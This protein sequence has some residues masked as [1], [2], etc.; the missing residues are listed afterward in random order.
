MHALGP[1]NNID[2]PVGVYSGLF[3][4]YL[5]TARFVVNVFCLMVVNAALN[6]THTNTSFHLSIFW[7]LVWRNLVLIFTKILLKRGKD[8]LTV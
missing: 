4:C 5:L 7:S 6:N 8:I 1:L 3:L 2:V